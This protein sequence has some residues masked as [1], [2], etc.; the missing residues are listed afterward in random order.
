MAAA[1]ATKPR[2]PKPKTRSSCRSFTAEKVDENDLYEILEAARAAPSSGNLQA[3]EIVVVRD[4]KARGKLADA[5]FGQRFVSEAPIVL[6][7][8]ANEVRSVAKYGDRGKIYAI[9]DAAIAAAWAQ[10]RAEE[11]GYGSCMVGGFDPERVKWDVCRSLELGEPSVMLC[12]GKRSGELQEAPE[13]RPLASLVHEEELSAERADRFY[14]VKTNWEAAK[15][16][17]TR[18]IDGNWVTVVS[19]KEGIPIGLPGQM[20]KDAAVRVALSEAL[21]RV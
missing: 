16:S 8:V 13:R 5:A 4:E 14:R 17:L 20:R 12:I 18:D 6:V 3:Y 19:P 11:L 1:I 21:R 10:L 9:Q 7:F 2:V 15:V